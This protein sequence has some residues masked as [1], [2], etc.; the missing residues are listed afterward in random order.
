MAMWEAGA[1]ADIFPCTPLSP[2]GCRCL[3]QVGEAE[4]ELGGATSSNPFAQLVDEAEGLDKIEDLQV[5]G[6]GCGVRGVGMGWA[7]VGVR[8]GDAGPK[9]VLTPLLAPVC[10]RPCL[11]PLPPP[12]ALP[13]EPQQRGH[14]REGGGHPGNLL[15]CGGRRGGKPG[16]GGGRGR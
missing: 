3:P 13:A 9:L 12:P 16:A 5:C 8:D 10:A 4:K 6:V 1:V 14:L 2:R 11:P 7:P 15:R